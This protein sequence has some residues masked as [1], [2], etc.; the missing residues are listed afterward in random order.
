MTVNLYTHRQSELVSDSR[1]DNDKVSV[2]ILYEMLKQVQQDDKR[3]DLSSF[4]EKYKNILSDDYK[5]IIINKLSYL[6]VEQTV[7]RL[8]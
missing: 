1:Y 6:P 5:T 8:G 2:S 7:E 4:L 3:K